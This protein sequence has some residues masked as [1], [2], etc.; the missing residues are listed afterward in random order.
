[1]LWNGKSYMMLQVDASQ[2]CHQLCAVD[3]ER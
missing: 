1:M 3:E 2:V